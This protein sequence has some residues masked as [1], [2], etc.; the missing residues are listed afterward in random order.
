MGNGQRFILFGFAK[1]CLLV[2]QYRSIPRE[3]V[4]V[5]IPPTTASIKPPTNHLTQRDCTRNTQSSMDLRQIPQALNSPSFPVGDEVKHAA[6]AA[7]SHHSQEAELSVLPA[8]AAPAASNFT[9]QPALAAAISAA[10][11]DDF[12]LGLDDDDEIKGLGE[13][14]GPAEDQVTVVTQDG[15]RATLPRKATVHSGLLGEVFVG[16]LVCL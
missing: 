13:D 8:A 12:V 2:I 1:I 16:Q 10:G 15:R 3:A 7:M 5:N 6:P 4:L 11:D 9:V 14:E